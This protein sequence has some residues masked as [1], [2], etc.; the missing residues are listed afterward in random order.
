[1]T[2]AEVPVQLEALMEKAQ[3][4]YWQVAFARSSA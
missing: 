2:V 4:P 3:T 1:V